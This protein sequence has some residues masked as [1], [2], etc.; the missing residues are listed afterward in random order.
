MNETMEELKKESQANNNFSFR[1]SNFQMF[2]INVSGR[3]A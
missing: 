1:L 2:N 3:K